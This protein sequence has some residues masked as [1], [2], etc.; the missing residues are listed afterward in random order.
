M[1]WVA[2]V[3]SRHRS[4]DPYVPKQGIRLVPPRFYSLPRYPAELR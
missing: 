2:V 3:V 4:A 1:G